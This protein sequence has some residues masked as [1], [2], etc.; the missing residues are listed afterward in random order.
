MFVGTRQLSERE[1]TN[2]KQIVLE[3]FGAPEDVVRCLG[4]PE[5]DPAGPGEVIFAVIAFPIN[6]ADLMICTGSYRI[7]PQL[8][9]ALGAE[10]V[11]RIVATGPD[12]DHLAPGDLVINLL[13]DNWAAKRKVKA[14]DVIRLPDGIDLR[15]AAMLRIN[16]PTAHLLLTRFVDLQP[17][18]WII[19]NAANSAVGR[20]VIMLAKARGVRTVNVVRRHDVVAE[21]QTLGGDVCLLDEDDLPRRVADAA[22]GPIRVGLDAVGGVSTRRL[23]ACV[24]NGGI[25]V[26][27]GR[28][29]DD[30]AVFGTADLIFRGVTLTGFSLRDA[31]ARLQRDDIQ[32]IYDAL[33]GEV[34]AGRLFVPVEQVYPIEAIRDAL[35]HAR[36]AG[37]AGKILVA[38]NGMI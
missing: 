13:R 33:I 22:G 35:I 31:F 11:G 7:R 32:S 38:P 3:R 21:L 2:L 8:P 20:L 25:V 23:G 15:Q 26:N 36:A 34:M 10:C 18:D 9:A 5:P 4:V 28:L 37:H 1:E 29:G 24:A 14:D 16:P 30:D 17:D 27:Y 6:P 12:V 19:Q